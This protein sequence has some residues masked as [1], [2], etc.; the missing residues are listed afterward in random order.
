MVAGARETRASSARGK[1]RRRKSQQGKQRRRATTARTATAALTRKVD[2]IS[3]NGAVMGSAEHA[4]RGYG[5][6]GGT[7]EARSIGERHGPAPNSQQGEQHRR[8]TT[9]QAA[10]A[11][12]AQK[13]DALLGRGKMM[14][15]AEHAR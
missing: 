8:V 11:A 14:G 3:G 15:S 1:G 7:R 9:A 4:R 12:S 6:D 13:V 2:A 10:T 5:G